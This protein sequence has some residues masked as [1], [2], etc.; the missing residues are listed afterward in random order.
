[1]PAEIMDLNH[2]V[3]PTNP[4]QVAELPRGEKKADSCA[5]TCLSFS[6]SDQWWE[7]SLSEAYLKLTQISW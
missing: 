1:M 6:Q 4:V 7:S 3:R 2:A 5:S